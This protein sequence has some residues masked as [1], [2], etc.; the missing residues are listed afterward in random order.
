MFVERK[1]KLRLLFLLYITTFILYKPNKFYIMKRNASVGMACLWTFIIIT[2]VIMLASCSSSNHCDAYGKVKWE[3][4][5]N[6]PENEEFVV[7]VAFNEGCTIE[8]VTQEQFDAR[9]SAGY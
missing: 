8:Q 2:A 1:K 9:Y 3:N 5:I 7:E 4:S 6:N